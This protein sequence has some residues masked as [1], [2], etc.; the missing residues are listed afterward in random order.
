MF[1]AAFVHKEKNPKWCGSERSTRG[2][3][4]PWEQRNHALW[5]SFEDFDSLLNSNYWTEKCDLGKPVYAD[6][7]GDYCPLCSRS[8][9]LK[10]ITRVMYWGQCK[11]CTESDWLRNWDDPDEPSPKNVIAEIHGRPVVFFYLS[12]LDKDALVAKTEKFVREIQEY[13]SL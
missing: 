10:E 7:H 9:D 1:R 5:E 3:Q 13:W 4:Y 11:E 8:G 6:S 12:D 2:D